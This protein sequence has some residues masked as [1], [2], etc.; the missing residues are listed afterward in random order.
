[1]VKGLLDP[2]DVK[3]AA[4]AGVD[5]V[6]VSTHGG[7][8][9]DGVIPSIRALPGCVAAAGD[10]PVMIDSGIR[11]GTDIIKCLALGAKFCFVGRPF[12]YAAIFGQEGVEHAI[13]LLRA[14]FS[15]DTGN[16][17]INAL[18]EIT[19]DRIVPRYP[20]GAI[21]MTGVIVATT[22]MPFD[23][24]SWERFGTIAAPQPVVRVDR[25]DR[26]AFRK[27]LADAEIAFLADDLD[28]DVLAAPNLKWV[29]V[30]LSGMTVSARPEIFERGLK[31]TGVAGRSAPALAEHAMMF[32][33]AINANLRGFE[34]AQRAHR[35]GGVE[36]SR[37]LRALYGKTVAILGVGAT[38][39]E[40]ALRAKAFGM[41]V[42]GYRRREAEVPAG[43][44]R[45]Y[46]TDRGE[47]L[48]ADPGDGRL[49]RSCHQPLRCNAPSHRR[50][51]LA[52]MKPDAVI[53]NLSR[54]GVIDE[55]ALIDALYARRIRGAG[56][57]VF[58]TE[59]LPADSPLLGCAEHA[60]LAAFLRAGP[61]QAAE[62]A[63]DHR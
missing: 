9:I 38:A 35:W 10:M 5:G 60:G 54:G 31:V 23:A 24:P 11:R 39:K 41:T 29:H 47:T 32:M 1:M 13:G 46:C 17:G 16:M 33:L 34:D 44:D 62:D 36:G 61:R 6:I 26:A 59:P 55:A 4:D 15:R 53:V 22:D 45:I 57:D 37:D 7:R 40:L 58:D 14:E 20:A 3:L 42:L 21:A 18:S 63:G 50:S 19:R 28:E 2:R 49:H 56:L 30:N 8:Q 25:K 27:A 12:N 52:R 51:E 43:F 48:A